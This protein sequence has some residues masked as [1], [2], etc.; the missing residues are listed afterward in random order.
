MTW[1]SH[2]QYCNSDLFERIEGKISK[3]CR[4][5]REKQLWKLRG[6]RAAKKREAAGLEPSAIEFG[7]AAVP[8]KRLE[9]LSKTKELK[10]QVDKLYT[11]INSQ[12][13]QAMMSGSCS[14]IEWTVVQTAIEQS[15]RQV[16]LARNELT[17]GKKE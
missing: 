6:E 14:Q 16:T 12:Q 1:C 13:D 11:S 9:L 3:T 7:E 2:K 8:L 5:H 17:K 10:D 15:Q 4:I